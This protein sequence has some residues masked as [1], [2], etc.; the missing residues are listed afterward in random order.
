MSSK[1]RVNQQHRS[2]FAR[3]PQFRDHPKNA[4]SNRRNP[5]A[6]PS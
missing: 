3:R 2:G 5:Q 4:L 1:T 6:G